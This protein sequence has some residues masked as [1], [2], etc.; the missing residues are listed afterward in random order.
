[1]LTVYNCIVNEHDFRLVGLAAIICALASFAAMTLLHHVRKS[2]GHMWFVWL[3]V[4]ATATGFGIWATHF[5]A[6]L[7]FS[8]GI[9]SGYN[10]GLTVLSLIA[11]IMLTGVGLGVGVSKALPGSTWLG[12]AIV[13]GGIASMHYTGMAA[14]EIAGWIIWDPK[15]VVA[16]IAL[17]A[18][19]GALALP[20]GLRGDMIKW[21]AYG[22]LLLTVAIC[23]HHFTAMGAVSIV[24]DLTSRVSGSALPASWLAI[25]VALA[26]FT[27][28]ILALAGLALDI[29]D[30]RRSELETD[31]MRGLA[32]AA[33]E[34]LIVCDGEVVTTVNN[35]FAALANVD[36]LKATGVALEAYFPD[37]STRL[38]LLGQP[39][40]PVESELRQADGS[41]I[42]V[43]LILRPVEFAG[44]QHHAI[45][46]RDLRARKQAEQHIRFLAHHDALTGLPNRSSFNMKLDQEIEAALATGQRL[47]VLCL[48]LDRFKEV[49]DLFG[50]A[51]GD[52]LLQTVAK[53]VTGVLNQNQMMAR[54]GGDEFAIILPAISSPSV[55]G[56]VAENI[57]EAIQG[58]NATSAT[59]ALISS[60]IGIAICPNDATD[61]Q[62]LLSSC[63]YCALP[64]EG[65]GTRYLSLLRGD[66]GRRGPRPA[67]AGARSAARDFA[68]GAEPGVPAA[69][70]REIQR[71]GRFRGVVALEARNARRHLAEYLHSDRGG[72]RFDPADR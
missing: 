39:N 38:K 66:N 9:P 14:F 34:G 27:I 40:Q 15:L 61:R 43:E 63:R 45:A 68:A 71:D 50:H 4:S 47:A 37:E 19:I 49:N 54:L 10:I 22:A 65:G 67:S 51:A 70:G 46:V 64:R 42:P 6:M 59:A 20:V 23:S 18:L 11:A 24:P 31:R 48:D 13:G 28:I 41:I 62:G 5:I 25:A 72:K 69:A 44:K 55:A 21:R 12:G 17:G 29:R 60:S 26:S 16:S 30:R 35:S 8:P 36:S 3:A 32:N 57:L 53:C 7:A 52:T 33:V 56:R 58:E 2:S 1:M